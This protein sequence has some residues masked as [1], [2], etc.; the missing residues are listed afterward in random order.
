[1]RRLLFVLAAVLSSSVG[2]VSG[3]TNDHVYRSWRWE[4]DPG[5]PRAAGLAGA[6]TAIADDASA[7][8]TNP[9]GL[10]NRPRT[11]AMGSLVRRGSGTIGP[12]D[13]L[14]A[15]TDLG[16]VGG[17]VSFG[18]RFGLG[19]HFS[20][21][22]DVSVNLARH[23][24]P[25]STYDAGFLQARLSTLGVAAGFEVTPR[26]RV[27][28]GVARG[29]LELQG[30]DSVFR[31][32]GDSLTQVDATGADSAVTATLGALYDVT[33]TLRVGLAA[34]TG[35]SFRVE[36][37]AFS[38]AEGRTVDR[39]SVYEL[40]VPDVFSA[41]V[42]WRLPANFRLTA[43]ADFVR[44]SQI[45]DALDVRRDLAAADYV[46]DDG[47]EGHIGLEWARTF[48]PVTLQIRGGLWSQAPGS[49]AYVGPDPSERMTFQGSSRRLRE[50][51]GA[52]VL[53]KAGLSVD[54]AALLGGDRPLFLA[55]ARYRF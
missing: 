16:L 44:Y 4:E 33:E 53:F 38:P 48:D 49:V 42:A 15:S 10:A 21:P 31:T 11:E 8:L 13:A 40:R 24:L 39:G 41:G 9:A 54:A 32:R 22:R 5:S 43:Q 37:T 35:G 45:R 20:D 26:L 3:Q 28:A 51:V 2:V 29:H 14:A 17:S 7:S 30:Q 46:L 50:G 52:S 47:L 18:R 19:L 12:G 23:D 6:F 27:G 36:R 55:G 34:H 1:M 25:D